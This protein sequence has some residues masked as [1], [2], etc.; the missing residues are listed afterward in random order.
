MLAGPQATLI[1][2]ES[3]RIRTGR[4]ALI[5]LAVVIASCSDKDLL[6]PPVATVPQFATFA[7]AAIPSVRISEIH[8]DNVGTDAG[9]SIEI[10]GPAGMDVTGYQIVLYNGNGGASYNTQTLTGTI[11][12]TCGARG[13]IVVTY[14]VN[15]IQ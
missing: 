4:A 11:P 2:T 12:A 10:S 3:M 9:E 6:S 1:H 7:A 5:A 13:V 14:P 8:Y 15:G